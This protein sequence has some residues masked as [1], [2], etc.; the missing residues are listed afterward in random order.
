MAV[1]KMISSSPAYTRRKE[2]RPT[3]ILKAAMKEFSINGFAATRLDD[4]ACRAGICKGTIYLYF[5]SKEELFEAVVRD[6]MIP[7]IEKMEEIEVRSSGKASAVLRE[8]LQIIHREL[9]STD[10][11]YIPKLMIGEGN[12]FPKLA[13]FYYREVITRIHKLLRGVIKRGVDTGEFRP[14]ALDWSLQT[15]LSPALSAAMWRV[16]FDQFDPMDTEAMMNSHIEMLLSAL[17]S[18]SPIRV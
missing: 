14:E 11:R 9:V 18:T 12:R 13:E 6:R 8:Q 4:V 3:E 17:T 15:M 16:V 7:Y 10:T 2:E 5:N 1:A